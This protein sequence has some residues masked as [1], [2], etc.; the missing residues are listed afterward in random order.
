MERDLG[1]RAGLMSSEDIKKKMGKSKKRRVTRSGMGNEEDYG[2]EGDDYDSEEYVIE[3]EDLKK[4]KVETKPIQEED[5]E[6]EYY[7]EEDEESEETDKAIQDLGELEIKI[8]N[9]NEIQSSNVL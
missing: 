9:K 7:D 8:K 2:S 6:E 1:K 4:K 3:D 5:V